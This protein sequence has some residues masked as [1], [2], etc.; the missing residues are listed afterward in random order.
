MR[1]KV[2]LSGQGKVQSALN[3]QRV[4]IDAIDGKI[5]KLLLQ[6]FQ[7][8]KRV[9]KIKRVAELPIVNKQRENEI[10]RAKLRQSKMNPKFVRS[11]Y[12]LIFQEAYR[13]QKSR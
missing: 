1:K 6:R 5:M 3:V 12:R 4:A 2:L 11:L 13:L 10:I 7:C 9:G 8:V